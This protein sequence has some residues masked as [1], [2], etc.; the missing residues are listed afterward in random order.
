[1]KDK[2]RDTHSA[3][4]GQTHALRNN[5]G[6]Y[7]GGFCSSTLVLGLTGAALLY[8]AFPPLGWW[9]VAWIAPV[10]WILLIRW[11][12]LAG[13][14]PYV[15]LW[16]AGF[17]YWLFVA[18]WIRLPHW[19][20][21]FGWLALASYLAIYLPLFI[22]ISRLAVHRIGVSVILSAPAVW[23]GLELLR[24][25]LLTGFSMALLGHTQVEWTQLIQISDFSGAYGVGFLIMFVAAGLTMAIPIGTLRAAF[26][27]L[28][29]AAAVAGLALAYGHF[30]L[31]SGREDITDVAAQ[32]A[33]VQGSIDVTF[34]RDQRAKTTRHY[35]RLS[36]AT[37]AEHP[38]LDA[39]VWPE[40][41]CSFRASMVTYA[42]DAEPLDTLAL[43][44]ENN[45]FFRQDLKKFRLL[46][47]FARRTS[48]SSPLPAFIICC[49]TMHYEDVDDYQRYNTA[50]LVDPNG[51]IA[52]RYD[53]MHPVMF[54]EYVPLG[55]IFPWL[56]SLTPMGYGLTPGRGPAVFEVTGVQLS[57]SICYE[58]TVPH[59]I[60]GQVNELRRRGTPPDA[61]VNLTNDGWFWGS[62]EL[63]LHLACGVFRAVENRLP[64][65]IAA[66]TG[67]SAWIDAQGR[68]LEK[69][70]RRAEGVVIAAI[71]QSNQSSLY[72][73]WGDW[74]AWICL[75]FCLV[76][77]ILG[78]RLHRK[79]HNT[80][81]TGCLLWLLAASVHCQATSHGFH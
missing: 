38:E 17:I 14:R 6:P 40:S 60:R 50:L 52:D 77:L 78:R 49:D 48:T 61:L 8:V 23:T 9:A 79:T 63:D 81:I 66:N 10:P 72:Q 51:E 45:Y 80:A 1:M 28:C 18:H 30:R 64:L 32:L 62:S 70:P 39:I 68:I 41:M 25:Y 75:G 16:L 4:P 57:P 22:A 59:L 65:L 73:A 74:F 7:R 36:C 24:G 27:P 55:N 56:Y 53:K 13:R 46:H 37:L 11:D 76:S 12:K 5:S 15:L 3:S 29:L 20:A 67:F 2:H 43:L 31:R 47:D 44:D 54:G 35:R 26:W 33:L 58:S 42:A 71:S 69:G 21:F 34:D 19:S